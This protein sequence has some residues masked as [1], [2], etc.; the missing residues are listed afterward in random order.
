MFTLL[1]DLYCN[2]TSFAAFNL[3]PKECIW[4]IKCSFLHILSL[5]S[6]EHTK[7]SGWC[8][9]RMGMS[10]CSNTPLSIKMSWMVDVK[11]EYTPVPKHC[12]L[13][14]YKGMKLKAVHIFCSSAVGGA[15]VSLDSD[16]G[17]YH[18]QPS[19]HSSEKCF[20]CCHCWISGCPACS[21]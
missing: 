13:K 5:I 20:W 9:E 7:I 14:V 15:Y 4:K 19:L 12:T 16:T 18:F 6:V 11:D 21:L 17:G 1:C 10:V 8:V 3:G 2:K